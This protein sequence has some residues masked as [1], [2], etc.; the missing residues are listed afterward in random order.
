MPDINGIAWCGFN[1]EEPEPLVRFLASAFGLRPVEQGPDAEAAGA[2][3]LGPPKQNSLGAR[4]QHIRIPGG[5]ALDITYRPPDWL[6]RLTGTT[7]RPGSCD[8]SSV[9]RP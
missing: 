6:G 8:G 9:R 1:V 5:L 2:V 4:W 3:V 7:A